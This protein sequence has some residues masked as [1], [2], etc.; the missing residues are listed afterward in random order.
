[1]FKWPNEKFRRISWKVKS[2]LL[3]TQ[4]FIKLIPEFGASFFSKK[5]YRIQTLTQTLTQTRTQT[6]TQNC[7]ICGFV[8]LNSVL[9][10]QRAVRKILKEKLESK[11]PSYF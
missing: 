7:L 1:M 2:S 4:G 3:L 8:L 11:S 9:L 10:A 6:R 5:I